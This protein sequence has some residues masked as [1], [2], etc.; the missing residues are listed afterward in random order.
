[1][2]RLQLAIEQIVFAR[3]DMLGLFDQTRTDDWFRVPPDGVSHVGWPVGHIAF[4]EYRLALWR[5]RGQQPW[6]NASATHWL[7]R[8]GSRTRSCSAAPPVR[9]EVKEVLHEDRLPLMA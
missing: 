8:K 3:N 1:M 4:S 9:Q 7:G 6:P 2:S 5:I